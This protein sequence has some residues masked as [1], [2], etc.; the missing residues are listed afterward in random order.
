MF[1]FFSNQ[2][3]RAV[4]VKRRT[5]SRPPAKAVRVLLERAPEEAAL[6]FAKEGV[7]CQVAALAAPVDGGSVAL[8]AERASLGIAVLGPRRD[9]VRRAADALLQAH[10]GEAR[11]LSAAAEGLAAFSVA[12]QSGDA[13]RLVLLGRLADVLLSCSAFELHWS[14]MFAGLEPEQPV[15]RY[16]S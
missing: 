9:A 5:A 4:G 16:G 13:D 14:G 3:A 8:A 6:A 12:L 15:P 11:G 7:R 1:P 2:A 10:F